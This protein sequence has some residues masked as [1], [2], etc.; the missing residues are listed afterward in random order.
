M[1]TGSGARLGANSGDELVAAQPAYVGIGANLGATQATV[2]AAIDR[3]RPL[4]LI[5]VSSLYRSAP[6]DAE[7]PDFINAVALLHTRL[8]PAELLQAL[9]AIEAAFGR[10][11]P[12]QAARRHAARTLDLDLLLH[13]QTVVHSATLT[14]PHPRLHLRAFALTPLLELAPELVVPQL[15]ALAGYRAGTA[16]QFI[17]RLFIERLS[18]P[19]TIPS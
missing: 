1:V 5:A 6:V 15:G 8:Q 10:E 13:G 2:L 7:G 3:L 16:D 12:R 11:R 17:E 14:L 19:P 4:G 18:P 9:L